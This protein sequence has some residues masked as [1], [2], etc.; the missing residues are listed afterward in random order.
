MLGVWVSEYVFFVV[1]A[2]V[3]VVI[4][5]VVVLYRR[6]W[7]ENECRV[8]MCVCICKRR[9]FSLLLILK[10]EMLGYI[11]CVYQ[12]ISTVAATF[13]PSFSHFFLFFSFFRSGVFFALLTMCVCFRCSWCDCDAR[14]YMLPKYHSMSAQETLYVNSNM[15][16]YFVF[17]SSHFSSSFFGRFLLLSFFCFVL[18]LLLYSL[19]IMFS[20]DVQI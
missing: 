17:L 10:S 12:W 20:V 4:I 3:A 13:F 1:V 19:G 6:V 2:A 9:F 15:M 5:G 7:R 14:T 11:V 8:C 18:L 16:A